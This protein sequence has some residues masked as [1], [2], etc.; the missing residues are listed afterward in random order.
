MLRS[1]VCQGVLGARQL[2]AAQ[3]LRRAV[4]RAS[5]LCLLAGAAAAQAV[6]E[7]APRRGHALASQLCSGCHLVDPR[8]SGVVSDGV[9][10]FM[11]IAV[12]LDDMTIE[13]RLLAPS[14]PAMPDAPLDREQ[15][16]DVVAYIR[17]LAGH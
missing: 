7:E 4:R 13:T 8:Q 1:R 3:V 12:Q 5:I 14:H 15:R 6:D 10:T 16:Q 17:S 2:P 11:S 9:P